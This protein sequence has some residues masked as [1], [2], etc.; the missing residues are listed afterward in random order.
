M[1][2]GHG[3]VEEAETVTTVKA[4]VRDHPVGQPCQPGIHMNA[5]VG[6]P[7]ETELSKDIL[8]RSDIFL[9]Y[10][11]QTRIEGQIQQLPVQH[12]LS[13]FDDWSSGRPWKRRPDHGV[14]QRR[15]RH[16]RRDA[17]RDGGSSV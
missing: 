7:G 9:E 11:P 15:L 1:L 2:V 12:P 14:R 4:T 6:M 16:R 8:L 10:P 5:V 3:A 17:R 13:N